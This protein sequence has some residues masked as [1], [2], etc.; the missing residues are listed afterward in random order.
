M[1][2]GTYGVYGYNETT[3]EY[4]AHVM[5]NGV[6]VDKIRTKVKRELDEFKKKSNC[7]FVHEIYFVQ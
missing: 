2:Y 7:S 5:C 6:Q 3:K 1:I 4:H